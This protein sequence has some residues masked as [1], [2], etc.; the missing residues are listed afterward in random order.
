MGHLLDFFIKINILI[1]VYLFFIKLKMW[2]PFKW[3]NKRGSS[4]ESSQDPKSL[5]NSQGSRILETLWVS[6]DSAINDRI[7]NKD[8]T[9]DSLG[10]ENLVKDLKSLSRKD[11]EI[12][13][14]KLEDILK[15]DV[16]NLVFWDN[17]EKTKTRDFSR[18][19]IDWYIKH[20]LYETDFWNDL[21]N[22]GVFFQKIWG[23]GFDKKIIMSLQQW[24]QRWK[25]EVRVNIP[26]KQQYH[27]KS[28]FY[29][30]DIDEVDIKYKWGDEIERVANLIDFL[31]KLHECSKDLSQDRKLWVFG[32]NKK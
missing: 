23:D 28:G 30:V 1:R 8:R 18:N 27:S 32:K 15:E 3:F 20:Y 17:I 31:Q 2:N 25:K 5:E 6:V 26:F 29:K 11:F 12:C 24:I 21:A 7:S 16:I 10:R 19:D 9:S 14:N 13:K 4:L 22:Q